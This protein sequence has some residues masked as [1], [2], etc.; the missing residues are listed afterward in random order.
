MDFAAFISFSIFASIAA[1]T[2]GPNNLMLAASGA[3]FG[4]KHTLRHI[5]GVTTGFLALVFALV[6]GLSS[7]F[8]AL[9]DLYDIMRGMAFGFLLL[10]AWKIANAGPI[11]D[12]KAS[13]PIG[14][15]TAFAFQWVN[16]KAFTVTISAITAYTESS[17][18]LASDLT[19]I[20]LIFF[21]VTIISTFAWTIA[22]QMIGRFLKD[23]TARR[24]FNYVMAALLVASLLPVILSL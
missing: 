14:F 19:L 18:S 17:T 7:L 20:L 6:M 9:P 1:I 21:V 11:E 15:G 22:G 12:A 16:P 4:L 5:A 10:L 23:D 2:P 3:N 13:K 8:A 24:I